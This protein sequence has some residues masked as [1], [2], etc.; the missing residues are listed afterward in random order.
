MNNNLPKMNEQDSH[1]VYSLF[2][3]IMLGLSFYLTYL[4]VKPFFHTL[5]LSAVLSILF[6]PVF[7]WI[8]VKLNG[9]RV[10]A[11]MLTVA[12]IAFVIIIPL[13]IL[14]F[15]LTDQGVESIRSINNWVRTTDFNELVN[16]GRAS[17]YLDWIKEKLPFVDLDSLDIQAKVLAFSQSFAQNMIQFGTQMATNLVWIVLQFA[18][19]MFIIFYFLVDGINMISRLKHLSPLRPE[20]ENSIIESLQRVVR[21]VMLGSFFVAFLQGIVAGIGFAIVGIPALFWGAMMCF[22]AL[23]PVVGASVIWFPA[24]TYLLI[25]GQWGWA[26][27]LGLWCLVIVVNID[28]FLRPMLLRGAARVS[29]FYIFMA[30]LGG[31][32]SFGFT[33]ILYG[34][35]I[36]SFVMVMLKIYS[37]EYSDLLDTNGQGDI[38]PIVEIVG[39]AEG[40]EKK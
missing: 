20:Q 33:G 40:E 27:F 38:D 14:A 19:S 6:S 34:P 1:R 13:F 12:L 24:V 35:L 22:A 11:A 17:V 10:T 2:L 18:L 25:V 26:L 31:V 9:R 36:L 37:E 3:L 21:G 7:A 30:I 29:T 5:V 28:T 15:G 16:N 39:E 23:I 32:Y 8:E 4:I